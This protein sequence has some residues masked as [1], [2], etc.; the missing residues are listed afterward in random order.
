VLEE[1]KVERDLLVPFAEGRKR[2]WL[3]GEGVVLNETEGEDGF[4][5]TVR[6]TARQEKRFREL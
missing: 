3:H 5:V 6:W 1:E 4:H 2:A